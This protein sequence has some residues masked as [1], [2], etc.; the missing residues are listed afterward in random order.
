MIRNNLFRTK[1][2]FLLWAAALSPALLGQEAVDCASCHDQV[3]K[4]ENTPHAALTCAGCHSEITAY[5]HPKKTVKPACADCHDNIA[6]DEARGVHGLARAKGNEAA[7]DCAVCHG[8][9]HEIQRPNS[10]A[11]RTAAPDTCGM[12]HSE[13]AERFKGSVHG[14]ALAAKN[15]AAPICT[16]CHGE[17][18]IIAPGRSESPVS[19]GRIRE[20]C[21]RCHGDLRLSRRFGLPADRVLSFDASFHGL[22]GKA[23]SQSVA[24]CASCHGYHDILP[25]SDPKSMVS[26]KNLPS[27]CGKCHPGAGRR[28]AIG[29]VHLLAGGKEPAG[30]LWVRE[31]YLVTIP[32]VI[33]LMALHN[34][35]DWVRKVL[36]LR[37]RSRVPGLMFRSAS[38]ADNPVVAEFRMFP[39]ERIQHALLLTSFSVLVWTGFALKYPDQWWA[40]PLVM[41]E[42][43]FPL[44]ATVHRVAA[45]VMMAA[46]V[47][48]AVSLI[49]NRKLREHWYAM[50]PKVSDVR[51]SLQNMAWLFGL[52]STKPA[53]SSH[54]Y[55]E[56]AEYWAVAWGTVVM[57]ITGVALWAVNLSLRWL[58]KTWLDIA[59]AIHFY[60]AV[61][62]TLAIV[63]WH[64]YSVIFD[65]DVYPLD[66]AWL[67]G[68]SPRNRPHHGPHAPSGD[69][70][71]T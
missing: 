49:V 71:K 2:C 26:A 40:R 66:T 7:P 35:G 32:I 6:R 8:D 31:I 45:V 9:I 24:N 60:E 27:T 48:H 4:L 57:A 12:C 61:L 56:K 3:K 43:A 44:R 16:D 23:G 65:P 36:Q 10:I 14:K 34:F 70:T 15:T 37:F 58:P 59:T 50:L 54:G 62:A 47:M 42:S 22:A 63:V 39:F 30:V 20:T 19:A 28:F 1:L 5:P 29:P 25:S 17:H 67:T 18:S 53:L 41:W 51:E 46:A 11:F 21:G 13:I 55:I 52:S 68:Y 69:S 38:T 33:G 64:L